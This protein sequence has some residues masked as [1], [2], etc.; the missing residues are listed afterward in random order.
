MKP[1]R[2]IALL[3]L[4]AAAVLI[5]AYARPGEAMPGERFIVEAHEHPERVYE[6]TFVTASDQ[7]KDAALPARRSARMAFDYG[8]RP[9]AQDAP[10][11]SAPN[12][13]TPVSDV[14]GTSQVPG[15]WPLSWTSTLNPVADAYVYSAA[16]AT[17]YGA[18]P[19]LYVGS[20]STS[21]TGRALFRF[22]LSSIPAGAM[23]QS[24][25]FQTYVVQSSSSPTTLDV[26]LKRVDASWQEMVVSWNTQP[27]YTGANNVLGVGKSLGYYS[28][29]VTSLVQTWVNGAPNR[30][31]ALMSKNETTLGWRGFTSREST[32]PLNPPRLVL[33]YTLPTPTPTATRTP[34]STPTA[35]ITPTPTNTGTPTVTSTGT[36]LSPT[37]TTTSTNTATPTVTPTATPTPTLTPT[38]TRTPTRTAT[39]TATPLPASIAG[40]VWHDRDRD[41]TQD[42]G[43]SGIDQ[44]RLDLIRDNA[45]LATIFTDHAGYYRFAG[46]DGG[47]LYRVSVDETT[48]P[49]P[50]TLTT[51]CNPLI[52]MPQAG[53][54]VQGAD[55]GYAAPATP[56]PTPTRVPS[57]MDLTPLGIEVV[58]ATQCFG[59]PADLDSCEG[60]D[61]SLPLAAGKLTVAR[62]YVGLEKIG[63]GAADFERLVDVEV[64]LM[65]WDDATGAVLGE[66]DP[67]TIP[68]VIWGALLANV[69]DDER[70]SANFFLDEDWTN[71][72]A[73]GITLYAVVTA[74][75]H[76]CP[77]CGANNSIELRHVRFQNQVA[78][79]VYPVRIHYTYRAWDT[80]PPDDQAFVDMF[81]TARILFPLDEDDFDVHWDSDRVLRVDYN[82]GTADGPSQLLDDLADRYVCY[83]DG[84]WAC[85][86]VEGH[87][88]GVF[89]QEIT[90]GQ[91]SATRPLGWG[92]MARVDDCVSIVRYPEQ[93]T[94]AHELGHNVGRFHAS[95]AHGEADG[96]SWEEWPYEHGSIV[97]TG[98]DP[99]AMIA[100][101]LYDQVATGHR[102][103]LMSYGG[104]RWTSPR[105]WTAMWNGV[106][107]CTGRSV[108]ASAVPARYWLVTGHFS[109]T[110]EVRQVAPVTALADA[111]PPGATGLYTLE[112]R[113]AD[114]SLL[115]SVRF[116]PLVEHIRPE[117]SPQPFRV[118]LADA[119]GGAQVVLRDGAVV[120]FTR[121]LSAHA[122]VV[123]VTEPHGG[124]LWPATGFGAIRWTASDADGDP[125][126]YIVEYSRDG[127]GAW[128]NLATGL[129]EPQYDIELETL[130]GADGQAQ[131]RVRANDGM[132]T[133]Y[134][135]SGFFTVARKPPR[136][137]I[138]NPDPG[139]IIPLGQSLWLFG[140]AWDRED[141]ALP[142]AALAW[143]DSVQ[144][145]LGHGAQLRAPGLSFGKHV[146]TL[147][148]TD[149]DGQVGATSVQIFVGS[150]VW[151]PLVLQRP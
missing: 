150:R 133:G 105:G 70:R 92:G 3:I 7:S 27:G 21:A 144:G 68:V 61:N 106:D 147:S 132:R 94:A 119:P 54:D 56:T 142:G 39:A 1:N 60:G 30:G 69:R 102:N 86:W 4:A 34:T 116:D 51:C 77:D 130:G 43:E 42:A 123:T 76:E 44:V 104:N 83:E 136:P 95:N 99:R 55:F 125:L 96:G 15:T 126:T 103:D 146:I 31:L 38:P 121:S 145:A 49:A 84:F 41:G 80:T 97:V 117:L 134:G 137:V 118:Y 10:L 79:D 124:A 114:G 109:P 127:G 141:G 13:Y 112:L 16:P 6:S 28:W 11:I 72:R 58:Q 110:L 24:A 128:V 129:T 18:A 98:F 74:H 101:P 26:E 59:E 85:G 46:L 40:R 50:Y 81:D 37:P 88:V 57:N 107:T 67:V 113:A 66:L 23:V 115:Q 64:R 62:V 148:A 53:Q 78:L 71:A 151:L 122:P 33:D 93:M 12:A 91:A 32:S 19:T 47:V 139:T 90:M 22:D 138:N 75:R 131:I 5:L 52:V 108:S 29:D 89:S 20:Q 45:T 73:D 35:T 140:G 120:L 8:L 65:A 135:D 82:L 111:A 48:V 87:Y 2:P 17:N 36:V 14:P 63:P 100:M 143:T 9:S 149:A 25:T